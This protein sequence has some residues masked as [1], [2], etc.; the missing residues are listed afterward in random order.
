VSSAFSSASIAPEM[1]IRRAA[2]AQ[3]PV[4]QSTRDVQPPPRR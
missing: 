4:R 3:A 1:V 2:L